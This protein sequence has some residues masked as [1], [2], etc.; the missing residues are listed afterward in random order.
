MFQVWALGAIRDDERRA[1]LLASVALFAI[2][3]GH[4]VL[5]TA[6]DALFLSRLPA[7]RLP[8]VYL[9]IAGAALVLARVGKR[10][11]A[12]TA[13]PDLLA[14]TLAVG[15]VVCLAFWF[16][17]AEGRTA[18]CY[19]LYLTS[20]LFITVVLVQFWAT[21]S[22]LFTITQA[23]RLFAVIG[24]G[25][26]LG[27]IAG[28]ALARLAS[29]SLAPRALL[30]LAAAIFL[31][32][33]WLPRTLRPATRDAAGSGVEEPAPGLRGTWQLVRQE[34]FVGRLVFLVLL[35][36]V[37][38]TLV[39][40]LFK[41]L[42]ARSVPPDRL[43]STFAT[44][45]FALNLLSLVVQLFVVTRLTR[46]IGL[47]YVLAVLPSLLTLTSV[48][49]ILG[50]G[51]VFAFLLKG[52]DGALRHSLHRTSME[53][54]YVPLAEDLR[55]RVKGFV[56]IIGQRGGQAL[57]SLIIL[58]LVGVGAGAAVI[59]VLLG[60]LAI[61][62]MAT[63]IWLRPF[64][65]DLFRRTLRRGVSTT[66]FEFPLLDLASL[67]SLLAA[68]SSAND[69]EVVAALDL[70]FEK[71]KIHLVQAY[72]L[73]HP[74]PAVVAHALELFARVGRRDFLPIAERLI[75]HLDPEV[76]AA[77]LR[78]KLANDLSVDELAEFLSD[79]SPRVRGTAL[80]GLLST[81]ALQSAHGLEGFRALLENEPV[82]GK[83]A[84][85]EAVASRPHPAL[86]HVLLAL[87]RHDDPSVRSAAARAMR[88]THDDVFLPALVE[89]LASRE[90]RGE[91]RESILALGDHVLPS[92]ADMLADE[93][94][95]SSIRFHLPRTIALLGT[96][97]ACD[98]LMRQLLREQ[99]GALRFKILK[100]L[101]F[102]RTYDRQV[103]F[104]ARLLEQALD[105]TLRAT[106]RLLD[107]RLQLVRG[108]ASNPMRNTMGREVLVT[109]LLHKERHAID[110]LF[111]LLH[112]RDT[113]EDFRRIHRSLTGT[114]RKARANG[115]ELVENL[116]EP[117]LR[118]AVTALVSEAPD[119]ERL[120]AGS[121]Y[122]RTTASDDEGVLQ[123]IRESGGR[124]VREIVNYHQQELGQLREA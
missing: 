74:S 97:E 28:S 122:H 90:A 50:G 83:I 113:R 35:S 101:S 121:A 52:A 124:L 119:G 11:R 61:G 82:E 22:E 21:V 112:L 111:R 72:I 20:A 64:Y 42:I 66:R 33:A 7:E 68:L 99:D 114:S 91:A 10:L 36:T 27:A 73:Y 56:E 12:R 19:L 54:L 108:G 63:A 98:V 39:D 95:P 48:G 49:F 117:P 1:S 116:L 103:R 31:A 29:A 40:F 58:G 4:T 81:D 14:R 86:N 89:M 94:L 107:W 25:G 123:E 32:A 60:I 38:L 15:S 110:R 13:P 3:A 105:E 106:F 85:A 76:R 2:M 16:G 75:G 59:A 109:L 37:V 88:A 70:L 46:S 77:V 57:A 79:P 17:W 9:A 47:I 120:S 18:L 30:L 23:K 100:V 5:E 41:S 80:A 84:L 65:L 6:R 93:K 44:T 53:L 71:D 96:Q 78:L 45:Y 62:W 115:L 26:V 67:E 104:D 24:L 34:P 69:Q 8:F 55:V 43:A 51:L 102:L 87:G 92:L 118:G